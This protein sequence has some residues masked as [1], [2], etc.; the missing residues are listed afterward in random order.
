M[1]ETRFSTRFNTT[2]SS[3]SSDSGDPSMRTRM[4]ERS[5]FFG[6]R[7]GLVAGFSLAVA[8]AAPLS[9]ATAT[10]AL[11]QASAGSSSGAAT[12][13]K[14]RNG[15][16][17]RGSINDTVEV[18]FVE[19]GRERTLEGKLL[20]ADTTMVV[21]ESDASG[22]AARK[23]IFFADVRSLKTVTS[24]AAATPAAPASAATPSPSSP[25]SQPSGSSTDAGGEKRAV[26]AD[27]KGVFILPM[28]GMVGT[29]MRHEQIDEIG[30]EA[31]KYGPGQIIVL[32]ID[33]GG[34]MVIESER[35]HA[36]MVELKKRH[37]VV[38]WIKEAISAAA[39][40]AMH[41]D[42]IY[43]MNVG[44]LGSITMFAGTK[45]IEGAE[46]QAWLENMTRIAELG[47]RSGAV[48]R[49]MVHKPLAVSYTIPEGGGPKDAIFFA[50][51]SGKVV[52][53]GPDTMLTLNAAEALACGFSDGTAD[54]EA[55]LAKLMGLPEWKEVND[56]GRR[57]FRDWQ[58]LLERGS[59]EI[60]K[61]V[62]Q[63]GYKGAADGAEAQIG[64]R[65]RIVQDLIKWWDRCEPCMIEASQKGVG[66][67]P[68]EALEREERRL[69]ELL[70]EINRERRNR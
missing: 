41:C 7:S 44:A 19:N 4:N 39:F 64:V 27:Y 68:K 1:Q 57:I 22:R 36:S 26:P 69:R 50:D 11:P 32:H 25:S 6:L 55:E 35:I 48:A 53:D 49:A 5:G 40:T 56:S 10:S 18:V 42:E 14:L 20:R 33:S 31:D 43:F 37:R 16:T 2:D 51:T 54:S 12:E 63:Y 66:V 47:G 34:G 9:L 17:W 58:R 52:L 30:R 29:G 3:S 46:L 70:A 59:E 67:P 61:L 24:A 23:S 38:A 28:K 13:L 65:L 62:Q 60:I 8:A 45:A 15:Q 21:I